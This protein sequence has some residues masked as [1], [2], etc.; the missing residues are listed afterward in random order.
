MTI[1]KNIDSIKI[2]RSSTIENLIRVIQESGPF[3]CALV[4]DDNVFLNVI[5]D[6]DIR[7][8]LLA[9]HRISDSVNAVLLVKGNSA[10]P[11]PIMASA[12]ASRSEIDALFQQHSLRQ[13]VLVDG[14]GCPVSV[15]DHLS[16]G[17]E[18]S[19]INR[20][21]VAV[22]MAG[23]FGTRLRPLTLDTPKPML[24]INGRPLLDIL[25]GK[26]VDFG[27]EK[28]Y[29]TT[30]YLA[31]KIV[32]HFGNGDRFGVPIQYIHE[33]APLGTGGALGLIE[34]PQLN[35]LVINGDILTELDF[36]L[37][38]A[39]HIRSN[40][41]MTIAGTQY[42]FQVPFGVLTESNGR[43]T[44]IEEKPQFGFLVNSGIYFVSPLA[45][46]YLPNP[47]GAFTMPEL[48]E[49]LIAHGK[50]I[51]CFPIYERWL[52]I[53]RPD[54]YHSAKELYGVGR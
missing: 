26:L 37:F 7:R 16:C 13:L 38:Q 17:R 10:R 21:F 5:T 12:H 22:V 28:I 18:L 6:G 20:P 35:T 4:Y 31:Q 8:S 19:H 48:A 42:S 2:Q 52:D 51:S 49:C 1:S 46:D 41:V 14:D 40:S 44:A 45:F 43:V 39:E 36:A 32:D 33:D 29:I 25:I 54:D 50:T 27:A 24:P 53:G 3:A 15:I 34:R 30:H 9:G 23:G 47:K 11:T